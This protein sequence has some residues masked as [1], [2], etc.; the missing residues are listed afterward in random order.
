MGIETAPM[1][2]RD[3]TSTPS[4]EINGKPA[5]FLA[6]YTIWL[7]FCVPIYSENSIIDYFMIV[8]F[9]KLARDTS[10]NAC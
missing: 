2:K 8:R 10:K 5:F 7:V 4:Q 1:G 3:F 6:Q 9:R